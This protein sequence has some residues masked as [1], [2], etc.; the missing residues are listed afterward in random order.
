[1]VNTI[2]L[3]VFL[4]LFATLCYLVWVSINHENLYEFR[5]KDFTEFDIIGKV[6]YYPLR[7]LITFI[8][9]KE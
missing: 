4:W 1:M 2:L 8:T 3:I 6:T 7:K 9:P 5:S